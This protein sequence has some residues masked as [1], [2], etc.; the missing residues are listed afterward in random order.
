MRR[1][2]DTRA[3]GFVRMDKVLCPRVVRLKWSFFLGWING[4]EVRF[5]CRGAGNRC[6]S[7]YII[8]N[9]HYF[10]VKN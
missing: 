3:D 7:V 6:H 8:G 10:R 9:A 5:M 2:G 4:S 1:P